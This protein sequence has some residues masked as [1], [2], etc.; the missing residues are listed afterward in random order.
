MGQSLVAARVGGVMTTWLPAPKCL[1][2]NISA[3]PEAESGHSADLRG[4]RSA[5]EPTHF[6]GKARRCR[7]SLPR[8]SWQ[9]IRPG[10]GRRRLSRLRTRSGE[11]KRLGRAAASMYGGLGRHGG[12]ACSANERDD[13]SGV[14]R[15]AIGRLTEQRVRC[16]SAADFARKQSDGADGCA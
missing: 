12:G 13:I 14:R 2:A 11:Q 16:E 15:S 5:S 8:R 4:L 1:E 7:R 3:V 6:G 10:S 9:R